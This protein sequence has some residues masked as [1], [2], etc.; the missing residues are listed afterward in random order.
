MLCSLLTVAAEVGAG[1]LRLLLWLLE[2]GLTRLL[3]EI[4]LLLRRLLLWRRRR[5]ERIELRRSTKSTCSTQVTMCPCTERLCR[6]KRSSKHITGDFSLQ[7]WRCHT[8][9][10]HHLQAD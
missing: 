5:L 7:I 2:A 9:D 1:W 8:G 4:R 10:P 3:A 6:A